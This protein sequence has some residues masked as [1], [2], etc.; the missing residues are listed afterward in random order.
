MRR[1]GIGVQQA[2]GHGVHAELRNAGCDFL[3]SVLVQ[4][5]EHGTACGHPFADLEAR[6]ERQRRLRRLEE[7]VEPVLLH[8]RITPE[9][10]HAAKTPG[11]NEGNLAPLAFEDRVGRDGGGVHHPAHRAGVNT[12]AVEHQ[13]DSSQDS[14][15]GVAG[16]SE[17]LGHVQQAVR[18]GQ[19]DVREGASHIGCQ[20]RTAAKSLLQATNQASACPQ[21]IHSGQR[22]ASQVTTEQRSPASLDS[23]AENRR[24]C[25]EQA[26]DCLVRACL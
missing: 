25:A 21:A 9:G 20:E 2:D 14:G 15:G 16:G 24:Y 8:P 7:D 18:P 22:S 26:S 13:P 19:H 23:P 17:R 6:G 3:G 11:G 4:R 1:I 10:Q 12:G 5:D